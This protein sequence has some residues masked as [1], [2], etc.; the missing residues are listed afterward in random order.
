MLEGV[1]FR[2]TSHHLLKTE[3]LIRQEVH[4][5]AL[6]EINGSMANPRRIPILQTKSVT[7]KQMNKCMAEI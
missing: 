5:W 7:K 4:F 6:N 3:S 1:V 2:N